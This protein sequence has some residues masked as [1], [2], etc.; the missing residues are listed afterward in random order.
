M[1]LTTPQSTTPSVPSLRDVNVKRSSRTLTSI[2]V[3][4]PFGAARGLEPIRQGIP[5]S[6]GAVK[7]ETNIRLVDE[8]GQDISVQT[9]VLSNW[10]D[11]SIQW[12]LLDILHPAENRVGHETADGETLEAESTT[13]E[14]VYGVQI[15]ENPPTL[16]SKARKSNATQLPNEFSTAWGLIKVGS[17]ETANTIFQI[18]EKWNGRLVV[19]L[20]DGRELTL[21]LRDTNI[22]ESGPIRTVVE[23][24]GDL[25]DSTRAKILDGRFEFHFFSELKLIKCTF[26]LGNPMSAS[27]PG[28][29]WELGDPG[30][31]GIADASVLLNPMGSQPSQSASCGW[32]VD[33]ASDG[34]WRI[35]LVT[36]SRLKWR[37]P[38]E[39]Q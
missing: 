32:S 30:S 26:T 5:L 34:G 7:D 20:M 18:D 10:A 38:M 14:K 29:I 21:D 4:T 39:L 2:H 23:M 8:L 3:T 27:H 19:R 11:G 35:A 9:R 28:G 1:S 22:L 25:V 36:L 31:V 37:R 15:F 6:R 16:E 13:C 24:H 33:G 17:S 12:L